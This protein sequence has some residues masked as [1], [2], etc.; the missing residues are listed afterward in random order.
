MTMAR[1]TSTV[2]KFIRDWFNLEYW[3][4]E[5]QKWRNEADYWKYNYEKLKEH[6]QELKNGAYSY[7]DGE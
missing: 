6:L 5:A 3:K 4:L 7:E 2:F 1:R